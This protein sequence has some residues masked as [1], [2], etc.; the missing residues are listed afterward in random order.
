MLVD[1]SF[2]L[3]PHAPKV[4]LGSSYAQLAEPAYARPQVHPDQ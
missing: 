4:D 1:G 3:S 2:S